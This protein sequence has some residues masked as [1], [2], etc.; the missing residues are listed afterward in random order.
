MKV[1]YSNEIKINLLELLSPNKTLKPSLS[2]PKSVQ[3]TS[4][5]LE[6]ISSSLAARLGSILF[7][8]PINFPT[9]E[10]EKYMLKSAQKKRLIVPSIKKE[11]EILSYGYS[12]KKVL[13]VHGWAGRSTQ[14]FAFADKLLEKGYMVISFDGPS[15]GKST[16]K[17]T[18]M[19]EFL[20][21]IKEID[22]EYG[23]FEAA[24]GHSFGG[25]CLYNAVSRFFNVKTFITIGSGDKVSDIIT[26]FASN[27]SLKNKS[28]KKIQN[29]LEKKWKLKVDDYASHKVAQNINI[30]VL[31]IHDTN[32]GDVSVSC[33]MDIRQN[34]KNGT[35]LITHGLGHTKILRNKGIVDKSVEFIIQNT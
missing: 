18:M 13:L 25:M 23:P 27:L 28:G 12:K 29:R 19:P 9:P 20:E 33:A 34:L 22:I 11:I 1:T 16:G 10:R 26:N 32:D 31:I 3:L 4:R 15:H 6:M 21:S 5:T 24:I 7:T 14:L 8:T 17:R 2:I 30:P 35:L